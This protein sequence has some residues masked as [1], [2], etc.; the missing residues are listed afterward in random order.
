M[1]LAWSN[2]CF[3]YWL[4]FHF[5][6]IGRSFD[7]ND[8]I[9]PF[10]S[11]HI[12][13]YEKSTGCFEQ[14]FARIPTAIDRSKRI[15][16]SQRKSTLKPIDCNP[17]TTVHELVEKLIEVAGMTVEQYQERNSLREP[18]QPK[19]KRTQRPQIDCYPAGLKGTV[20]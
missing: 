19:G 7:G 8:A 18:V 15:H 14:I 13:R 20:T 12:R 16:G 9:R 5:E 2:P 6:L 4:L 1:R 3:E 10:V 11:R 17:A